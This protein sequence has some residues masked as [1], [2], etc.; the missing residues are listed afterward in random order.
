MRTATQRHA[1]STFIGFLSSIRGDGVDR[2]VRV[3]RE[4]YRLDEAMSLT[5]AGETVA[6]QL[7]ALAATQLEATLRVVARLPRHEA[8]ECVRRRVSTAEAKLA[9]VE[10]RLI[11]SVNT[12]ESLGNE[13][14]AT[15]SVIVIRVKQLTVFVQNG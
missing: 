11:V 1:P 3:S 8:R 7:G 15:L 12:I 9:K 6:T 14:G 5:R 2:G 13:L 4:V 10:E